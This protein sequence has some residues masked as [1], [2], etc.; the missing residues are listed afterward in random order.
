MGRKAITGCLIIAFTGSALS[1]GRGEEPFRFQFQTGQTLTYNVRQ[2]TT[3]RET[4]RDGTSGEAATATT[5]TQL[6]VT[7][8]WQVKQVADDGVA[9]LEMAITAMRQEIVRPGPAD[10]DGRPTS[11]T[12]ILDSATAE[13]QKQL[14]EYLN[15]PILRIR[16]DPQGRL[17]E[18]QSSYGAAH[19]IEAELPFR[20][21]WPAE[22][23]TP[24]QSWERPFTIKLD[25]PQGTGERHEARQTYTYKG[26]SQGY[27]VVGISTVLKSPP[28]DPAELPGLIPFLWEGDIF[29]Q[30]S[31]GRYA[32]AKLRVRQEVPNHLGS[33][34]R[35]VYES[36]YAESAAGP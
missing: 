10:K 34:S 4:S 7:R 15:K 8:K 16:I 5:T 24:Q 19:R 3:V 2:T 9:T 26:M 14:A 22:E 21:I 33:G 23:L 25:P 29:F 32:G 17:R 27:A 1:F 28:S 18:A 11:D 36:D 6:T 13:G 30:P 31:R 35:F 12:L 20:L